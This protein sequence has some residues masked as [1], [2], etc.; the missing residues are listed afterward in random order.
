MWKQ[1][2]VVCSMIL[3]VCICPEGTKKHEILIR[4]VGLQAQIR[5]R[6]LPNTR[7]MLTNR[8]LCLV[9]KEDAKKVNNQTK[10]VKFSMFMPC[11]QTGKVGV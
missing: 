11:R 2:N 4:T 10:K 8:P 9:R 7:L 5:S 1:E 6:D 3:F